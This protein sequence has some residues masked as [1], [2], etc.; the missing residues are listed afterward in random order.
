MT[1]KLDITVHDASGLHPV[2]LDVTRVY[3]LGFTIRDRAQMQRHLD[4]VIGVSVAWPEK[5]P[6]IFP[7]SSWATLITDDV[8]V[9]YET[10]SGEIE[11]VMI[12]QDGKLFVTCGSDHTD[13]EL[14]KTDIPWGKQVT[15]NIFAP[16]VWNWEE[17]KDHWDQVEMESYVNGELYQKASVAE[18][19]SPDEIVRSVQGR[20]PESDGTTILF[21]GTVV[22]VDGVMDFGLN[23]SL[24]MT[25]PVLNRT[26]RHDYTVT[27]L[28]NEI[29]I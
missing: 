21:S 24:R 18:F 8:P 3:N 7:I 28:S 27:V 16:T 9:Q 26:I 19:W 10:T 29:D 2:T 6:V 1:Q 12:K 17:V 11:I 23:W 22:S 20:I 15:P 5:P 13:R 14:E 25:D 4:E